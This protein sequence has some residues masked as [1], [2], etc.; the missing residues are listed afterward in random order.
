MVGQSSPERLVDIWAER[1]CVFSENLAKYG[2]RRF[3]APGQWTGVDCSWQGDLRV[4]HQAGPNL[5]Q[6]CYLLP[7]LFSQAGIRPGGGPVSVQ[8]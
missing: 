6:L 1:C 4:G 2:I 3:K 8:V 7:P 5:A